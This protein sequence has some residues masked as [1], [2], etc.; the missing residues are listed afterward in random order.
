MLAIQ[1][2]SA[3]TLDGCAAAGRLQISLR[4]GALSS[5]FMH[6]AIQVKTPSS[7]KTRILVA[8]IAREYRITQSEA[9]R[10][11]SRFLERAI[12][13][14]F[15]TGWWVELLEAQFQTR[16]GPYARIR[17]GEETNL[18]HLIPP[19]GL[20]DDCG[21][22]IGEYHVFG[23]DSEECSNC[24]GQAFCCDCPDRLPMRDALGKNGRKSR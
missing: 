11:L 13:N 1:S 20:C 18:H 6:M 8:A 3:S 9:A 5:S 4:G 15:V 21:C 16:I 22:T 23:C 17:C 7:S 12:R 14:Y 19:N 24:Y 10:L 2:S